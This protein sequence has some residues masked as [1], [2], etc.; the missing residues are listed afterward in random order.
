MS[1]LIKLNKAFKPNDNQVNELLNEITTRFESII[2]ETVV[3]ITRLSE[4]QN[5]NFLINSKQSK[6]Y[7][8]KIISNKGYPNIKSLTKCYQLL[9]NIG[10]TYYKII[11]SDSS[12]TIT[13]YGF[14]IQS[15]IEGKTAEEYFQTSFED[16][17]KKPDKQ[18]WIVHYAQ[19][20]KKIHKIDLNYFGDLDHKVKFGSLRDYYLNLDI[21]VS[22]SFGEAII[23]NTS[24]WNLCKKGIIAKEFLSD[25]FKEIENL[26]TD[27]F[28][29]KKPVLIYGDMLP[30]NLI[31]SQ[32]KPKLIDW[33]E[34]KSNWW[35]YELA[36]TLYYIDSMDLAE[37]FLNHYSFSDSHKEIDIGIRIEHIKQDLRQIYF[38]VINSKSSSEITQKVNKI[39]KR[40]E[41]SIS[42]IKLKL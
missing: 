20:L 32:N 25:V 27:L 12:D 39:V 42:N 11:D 5:L 38:A 10:M 4:G 21:V 3:T 26:T 16:M 28:I 22:N 24:L 1:D 34:T 9:K 40:I 15:W 2:S 17:C 6:K 19:I 35:V 8:L 18:D 14:L 31:Y 23:E 37:K 33:D 36:R 13:P 7:F 30:T 29:N 41:Q